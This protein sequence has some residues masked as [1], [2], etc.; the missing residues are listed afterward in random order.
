[1]RRV[2]LGLSTVVGLGLALGTVT[3]C[4]PSA[5]PAPAPTT[6]EPARPAATATTAAATPTATAG[7]GGTGNVNGALVPTGGLQPKGYPNG[8]DLPTPTGATGDVCNQTLDVDRSSHPAAARQWVGARYTVTNVVHSYAAG[9]GANAVTQL[10]T[11]AGAC[12]TYTLGT[13]TW[14]LAA[15]LH[16]P[17]FY[18]IEQSFSYCEQTATVTRCTAYFAAGR[19][20]AVV[21]V[22]AAY[23]VSTSDA[24]TELVRVSDVAADAVQSG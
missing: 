21:R 6:S 24:F 22:T 5:S 18:G 19:R 17:D 9:S 3:A 13:D 4:G 15:P 10:K 14:T 12:T 16:M 23:P 20:L 2:R 1:M 11:A 7:T 8:T